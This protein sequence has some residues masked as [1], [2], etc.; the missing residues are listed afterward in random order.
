MKSPGRAPKREWEVAIKMD[1]VEVRCEVSNWIQLARE[2]VQC[3][4]FTNTATKS[5]VP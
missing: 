3:P 2:N 5:Q 1:L 4:N